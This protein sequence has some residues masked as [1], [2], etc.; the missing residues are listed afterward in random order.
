[1]TDN[2]TDLFCDNL[3]GMCEADGKPAI[4]ATLINQVLRPYLHV[5]DRDAPGHSTEEVGD[6]MVGMLTTMLAN[7]IGRIVPSDD[8]DK[9]IDLAQLFVDGI[10]ASLSADI[11][12]MY[13]QKRTQKIIMNEALAKKK[14]LN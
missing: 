2:P 6:A 12:S 14:S 4:F 1:M 13:T 11:M 3:I 7:L 9:A 10:S 8:Q 5:L